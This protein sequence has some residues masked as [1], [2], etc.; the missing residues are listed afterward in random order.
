[1]LLP[2]RKG[3]DWCT[4]RMAAV[5]EVS[6]AIIWFTDEARQ[7]MTDA[8]G[9]RRMLFATEE[10]FEPGREDLAIEVT[11]RVMELFDEGL[12]L[13]PRRRGEGRDE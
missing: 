7:D 3:S 11:P 8:R 5:E 12:D 9:E 4:S 1:M 6:V 2:V 10:A 13:S